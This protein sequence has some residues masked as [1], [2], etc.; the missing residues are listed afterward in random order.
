MKLDLRATWSVQPHRFLALGGEEQMTMI[1]RDDS[2]L[3]PNRGQ[4]L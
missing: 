3:Y 1:R 2:V 4:L